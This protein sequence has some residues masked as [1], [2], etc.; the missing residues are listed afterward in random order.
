MSKAS[1]SACKY[2]REESTDSEEGLRALA[3]GGEGFPVLLDAIP[4]A[5]SREPLR[6]WPL[7]SAHR[8]APS[9][10]H[11]RKHKAVRSHLAPLFHTENPRSAVRLNPF[12]S[13]P[14]YSREGHTAFL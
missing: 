2:L 12:P 7:A 10:G 14:E 1:I 8:A 9:L 5:V 3:G 6:A 4:T 13:P 11:V